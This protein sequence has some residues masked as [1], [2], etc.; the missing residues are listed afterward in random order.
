[1]N[2]YSGYTRE[3]PGGY[4]A[5]LRFARDGKP[6]PVMA[7]GGKPLVYGTELEA[8]KAVT[9][10]LLDYFNG[11]FRRDGVTISPAMSA[12]DALFPTLYRKGRAIPVERRASA[13]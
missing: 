11:D 4:W 8:Q 13:K 1:M 5:M 12:A 2:C 7:D 6:K 9:R 3:V 10:H